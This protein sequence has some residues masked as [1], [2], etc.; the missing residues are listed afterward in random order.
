VPEPLLEHVLVPLDGS[1]L[2]E[3]VLGPA[4]DL[5]RSWEGRCTLLRVVEASPPP[6]AGRSNRPRSPQ[7]E[8]EAAREYL[9]KIAGRLR[10]EGVSVRTRVVVAPHAAPV[11]LEEVQRQR[12]DFIALATHGRGGLRRMLLGSIADKVIR[13][14]STPVLVY[15]PAGD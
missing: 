3:R 6:T 9:E 14:A 10:D 7:P 8:Q 12:G 13:G 11:I 4:L 1:A 5:V 2:A 15:R